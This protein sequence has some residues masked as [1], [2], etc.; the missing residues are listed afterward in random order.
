MEPSRLLLTAGTILLSAAA[1]AGFAQHAHRDDP[2]RFSKWRVVHAGGTAGAVQLLACAAVWHYLALNGLW[3]KG[4]ATGLSVA[5]WAF[6]VGPL[7]A[8]LGQPDLARIINRLGGVVAV[9]SY[10]ALPVILIL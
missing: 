1:L 7:C 9:P 10:L 2:V 8:A 6:F 3:C 5:T 4:L